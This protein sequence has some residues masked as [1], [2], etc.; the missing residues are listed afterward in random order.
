[1][2]SGNMKILSDRQNYDAIS[3]PSDGHR[4]RTE[5][6]SISLTNF[7]LVLVGASI[8]TFCFGFNAFWKNIFLRNFNRSRL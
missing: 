5:P 7:E 4:Y 3:D 2:T 6:I 1:M 8:A